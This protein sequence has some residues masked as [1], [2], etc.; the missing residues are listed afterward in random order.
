M[1]IKELKDFIKTSNMRK[2][3]IVFVN[4]TTRVEYDYYDMYDG[5]IDYSDFNVEV[6]T[7]RVVPTMSD[8]SLRRCTVESQIVIYFDR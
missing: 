6:I 5:C 7:S 8:N 1:T 2:R 3:N 4:A